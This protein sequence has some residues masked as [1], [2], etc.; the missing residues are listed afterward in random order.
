MGGGVPIE[1]TSL[2]PFVFWSFE[3]LQ[4]N[5][6]CSEEHNTRL[7][8]LLPLTSGYVVLH[9]VQWPVLSVPC[10]N[11]TAALGKAARKKRAKERKHLDMGPP[12]SGQ[13]KE[14]VSSKG[15]HTSSKVDRKHIH[16]LEHNHVGG[17]E[18]RAGEDESI[19]KQKGKEKKEGR[20]A[21]PGTSP[22]NSKDDPSE[23]F[24]NFETLCCPTVGNQV[25]M[26]QLRQYCKEVKLNTLIPSTYTTQS[27]PWEQLETPWVPP[28][29]PTTD[30]TAVYEPMTAHFDEIWCPIL[31]DVK[32]SENIVPPT[33][34][35]LPSNACVRQSY[36]P[37]LGYY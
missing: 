4:I 21:K 13:R 20:S 32:G 29:L 22:S 11:P 27:Q 10:S 35:Y 28:P 25:S 33:F 8:S 26:E 1:R 34:H 18:G 31:A 16:S 37:P 19:H 30:R 5:E 3:H 6:K 9:A 12:N 24:T 2:R 15:D 23:P 14:T 17:E 36:T 7:R